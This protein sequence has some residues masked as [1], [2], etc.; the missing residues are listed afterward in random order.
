MKEQVDSTE[1]FENEEYK[2]TIIIYKEN[3]RIFKAVTK[4]RCPSL[5][6]VTGKEVH[7]SLIYPTIYEI[8]PTI[9]QGNVD[10]VFIKKPDMLTTNTESSEC[11]LNTMK[12][13]SN[14][15]NLSDVP[16][17]VAYYGC[18]IE[19][20]YITGICLEQ[21]RHKLRD[22][23]AKNLIDNK[24]DF[25]AKI[26]LGLCE[27]HKRGFIHDDINPSNIMT[28][29]IGEPRIIDLDSCK[30]IGS[31]RSG[32]CG[33]QEWERDSTESYPINDFHSL[34]KL[35]DYIFNYNVRI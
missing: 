9:F 14:F 21:C 13:I 34:A 27:L 5:E 1:A 10:S 33:T 3:G 17:L 18:I 30:K 7:N 20:N 32:K 15:Q 23:L 22:A 25:V 28:N 35:T 24:A 29:E 31:P 6:G 4:Q 2:F 11:K 8:S 26:A 12:E 16:Y 19:D